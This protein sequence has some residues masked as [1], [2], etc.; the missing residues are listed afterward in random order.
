MKINSFEECKKEYLADIGWD[1]NIDYKHRDAQRIFPFSV[2]IQGTY[3]EG[4]IAIDWCS[5]NIGKKEFEWMNLWYGKI[6]YDYGYWEFFFKNHDDSI[7]FNNFIPKIYMELD[8][9]KWKTDGYENYV[10]ISN[11]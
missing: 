6:G 5:N 7:L 4:D 10:A 11:E 1:D 3:K 8:G 2:I 9:E